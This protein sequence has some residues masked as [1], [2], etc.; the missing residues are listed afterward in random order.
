MDYFHT[1]DATQPYEAA[2]FGVTMLLFTATGKTYSY[3]E[4]EK[5]LSQTGFHKF[6]RVSLGEGT[7]ILVAFKK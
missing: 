1:R 4:T 6:R 7:G 2:L 5:L 3:E